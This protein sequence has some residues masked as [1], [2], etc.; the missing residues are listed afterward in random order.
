MNNQSSTQTAPGHTGAMGQTGTQSPQ[1]Q[2][3]QPKAQSAQQGGFGA[4]AGQMQQTAP[5]TG[6]RFTDW[7]SI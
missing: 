4:A 6:P 3:G 7:A 5:G 2:A 1:Q